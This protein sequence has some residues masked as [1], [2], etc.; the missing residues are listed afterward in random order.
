MW[1]QGGLESTSCLVSQGDRKSYFDDQA[2]IGANSNISVSIVAQVW[3]PLPG[4][5]TAKTKMFF[6]G[7]P[8]GELRKRMVR[9]LLLSTSSVPGTEGH[10]RRLR[11]KMLAMR[12]DVVLQPVSDE[13]GP[14]DVIALHLETRDG[15]LQPLPVVLNLV[16]GARASSSAEIAQVTVER[17]FASTRCPEALPIPMQPRMD[18]FHAT[19]W[20][21]CYVECGFRDPAP[22]LQ[23]DRPMLM[24][25]FAKR[26]LKME[27]NQDRGLVHG[28]FNNPE[29]IAVM[30]NMV[31]RERL[32][33]VIYE[34]VNRRGF[35]ERVSALQ[36]S[37]SSEDFME[38]MNNLGR[39][40]S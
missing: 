5:S 16:L 10:K 35:Q 8:S 6:N 15:V 39:Q 34:Y 24:E 26:V 22:G 29:V 38:A 21:I 30:G 27:E 37:I 17:A 7:E 12:G 2:N 19:T 32:L 36:G 1:G 23:R 28:H 3:P 31:R 13:G 11:L 9:N 18:W 40:E 33:K 4:K 25:E 20:L 14:D